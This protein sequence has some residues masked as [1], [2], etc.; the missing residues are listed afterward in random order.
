MDYIK[1]EDLRE[2]VFLNL[3]LSLGNYV[4]AIREDP[5]NM[6]ILEYCEGVVYG[7]LKVILDL[8]LITSYDLS[9]VYRTITDYRNN[10]IVP[11]PLLV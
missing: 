4:K 10:K 9:N 3:I 5:T 7:Q 2:I 1:L 8:K 11:K 6:E